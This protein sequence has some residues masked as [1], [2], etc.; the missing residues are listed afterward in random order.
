MTDAYLTYVKTSCQMSHHEDSPIVLTKALLCSQE[1]SSPPSPRLTQAATSLV[2]SSLVC[3]LLGLTLALQADELDAQ[4]ATL[5]S[6]KQPYQQKP[7][8]KPTATPTATSPNSST[9]QVEEAPPTATTP[10]AK[11][12]KQLAQ[13]PK[14]IAT[15]SA[16]SLSQ[17]RQS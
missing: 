4:I 16:P 13:Q 10:L 9:A 12:L 5:S 6:E 11:S 7:A 14:P 15:S 1:F 2:C 17:T 3:V 8:T